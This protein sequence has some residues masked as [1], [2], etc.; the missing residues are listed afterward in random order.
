IGCVSSAGRGRAA[1][2]SGAEDGDGARAHW[3]SHDRGTR[4]RSRPGK[5]SGAGR[6]A[7]GKGER[8]YWARD[9]AVRPGA[10]HGE[11]SN[12]G[13][14]GF[15]AARGCAQF[16]ESFPERAGR[17]G[18][19]AGRFARAGGKTRSEVEEPVAAHHPFSPAA[20]LQRAVAQQ[21]V[22]P[23]ICAA[24]FVVREV[25]MRE[26]EFAVPHNADLTQAIKSIETI[27]AQHELI[28]AMKGSLA[29]YPG[30][31]HW[32][33]KREKQKGTL[34][35]TLFARDRCVWAKVQDGRKAPGIER[36]LPALQWAIERALQAAA[37]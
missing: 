21:Q 15:A 7:G 20:S 2:Y 6:Q 29:A 5:F 26:I 16:H 34:E 23:S 33:D 11:E 24:T 32:H 10:D 19:F 22:P 4:A 27:C 13:Q 28:L 35:L 3:R 36:D 18:R 17:P 14:L 8:D 37:S 12:S 30:C 25:A 31:I 9:G 1:L